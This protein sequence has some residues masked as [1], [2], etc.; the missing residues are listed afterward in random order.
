MPVAEVR[1]I[2]LERTLVADGDDRAAKV[3]PVVGS[4]PA[5]HGQAADQR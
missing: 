3:A 2:D 5:G 4:R 1:A